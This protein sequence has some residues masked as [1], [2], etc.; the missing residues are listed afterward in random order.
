M[1]RQCLHED[2]QIVRRQVANG[3]LHFGNQC[4]TCGKWEALAKSALTPGQLAFAEPYDDGL[5]DRY[6][7]QQRELQQAAIQKEREEQSE[8]W[9]ANYRE[10][11]RS[12]AWFDKRDRVL[13]RDNY[14]CQACLKR[15]ATQVHH[16]T[17]EHFGDEPLFD[18]ESICKIC[19]DHL[20]NLDRERRNASH[21]N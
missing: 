8:A 4:K 12:D 2:K 14:I 20:T 16:L 11:M 19:H 21:R 5:S 13:K 7:T 1:E 15:K 17:Y 9:W 6:W 3:A 18:L 10:Y